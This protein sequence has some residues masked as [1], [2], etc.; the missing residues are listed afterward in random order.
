M[1]VFSVISRTLGGES[2][3]SAEKQ[4]VYSTAPINL[5][6]EANCIFVG[7]GLPTPSFPEN[8]RNGVGVA[9]HM[10]R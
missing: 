4:S 9:R 3:H 2:Y 6:N 10:T 5:I 1:I 8:Q 7:Y